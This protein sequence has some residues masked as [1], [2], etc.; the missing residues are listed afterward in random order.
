MN[1][2]N[3]DFD[4]I[5]RRHLCRHSQFGLNLTHLIA[6]AGTYFGLFGLAYWLA[7]FLP[8]NPDWIVLGILAVYFVVLAFNIPVRVFL[9]NVISILLILALFKVVPLGPWWLY[10][11]VYLVLIV[12]C[13]QFQNWTHKFYTKHRDMSEFAEK[14][15]K[16]FTLFILLSL[17]ELPILLNYL[18]FDRKNWT[19]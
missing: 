1:I 13:H 11:W 17:Y 3:I 14:Y 6:V 8:I 12:L 9:V 19:A 4:E 16:G 5:Y 2:L 18:A 15:P 7:D 10:P